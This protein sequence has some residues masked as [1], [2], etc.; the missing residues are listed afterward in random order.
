MNRIID[1]HTH[2][3]DAAAALIAVDPRQ[4]NPQPG[5][6]YS[7]GF[8]P[9]HDVD[10]LTDSDFALLEQCARHPKVLAIGETGLDRIRGARLDIQI[11]VFVRHLLLAHQLG[12]PVVVIT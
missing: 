10:T 8:H 12:L 5:Q 11:P 4:F 1:F 7:V 2:R 6:F 3:L 9:W